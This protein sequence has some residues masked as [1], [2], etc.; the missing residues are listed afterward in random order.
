MQ[1]GLRYMPARCEKRLVISLPVRVYGMGSDGK[2]FTQDAVTTD[3][4]R[5]GAQINSVQQIAV[6]GEIVGVQYANEKTRF[7]VMWVGTGQSIGHIGV[8][9]LEHDKCPWSKVLDA[10]PEE[11]RWTETGRDRERPAKVPVHAGGEL[12]PENISARVEHSTRE[13]KEIESLIESGAVEPR[14]LQE[15]RE[16]VNHVRQTSWAVQKWLELRD[17][18]QDPYTALEILVVER[19]RCA[20]QLNRELA[21]D[22]ESHDIGF[23]TKGIADL[24]SAIESLTRLLHRLAGKHDTTKKS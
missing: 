2:P 24:S 4:T 5:D 3:I 17:Q 16:A 11:F 9:A 22:I 7:K 18:K 23:E 21:N 12:R 6:A 15:F 10:A 19:I 20:T 1:S 14:I 13:L 8:Q